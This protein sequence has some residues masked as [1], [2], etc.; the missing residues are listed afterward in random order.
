[1]TRPVMSTPSGSRVRM[2]SLTSWA[3]TPTPPGPSRGSERREHL[4][5]PSQLGR[6]VVAQVDTDAGCTVRPASGRLRRSA[7]SRPAANDPGRPPTWR[8]R[9]TSRFRLGCAEHLP[10][11]PERLD[12]AARRNDVEVGAATRSRHRRGPDRAAAPVVGGDAV[13]PPVSGGVAGL[14]ERAFVASRRPYGSRCVL[15]S[16]SANASRASSSIQPPE[17]QLDRHGHRGAR[18]APAG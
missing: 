18:R 5:S 12:G 3:T 7:P 2:I 8:A 15:N 16:S 17:D 1:M 6:R 4:R 11:V 14:A 13:P 9:A 10:D